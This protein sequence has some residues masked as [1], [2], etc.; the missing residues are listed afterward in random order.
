MSVFNRSGF[1]VVLSRDEA[2]L[3]ELSGIPNSSSDVNTA[4]PN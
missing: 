4:M 1:G 3:F 2:K